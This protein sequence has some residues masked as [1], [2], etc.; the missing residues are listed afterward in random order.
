MIL[1]VRFARWCWRESSC[2]TCTKMFHVLC[3]AIL[4][5]DNPELLS[6]I[7][8][9]RNDPKSQPHPS[10]ILWHIENPPTGQQP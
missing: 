5:T 4:G 7:I 10:N 8:I 3:P 6:E 9:V 2:V 1:T